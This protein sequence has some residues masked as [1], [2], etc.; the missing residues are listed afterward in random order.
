MIFRHSQV[1][2]GEI[3]K[4]NKYIAI[5]WNGDEAILEHDTMMLSIVR[6]EATRK[7]SQRSGLK[8]TNVPLRGYEW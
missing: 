4:V 7:G 5:T 6:H 1:I 3:L 2:V 8:L